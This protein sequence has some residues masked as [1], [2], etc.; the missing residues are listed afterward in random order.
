MAV[1]D[2]IDKVTELW[3]TVSDGKRGS[4][5]AYSA[6]KKDDWPES[7]NIFPSALSYVEH[8]NMEYG[9]GS[10]AEDRWIGFTEFHL[11]PDLGKHRYPGVLLFYNRIKTAV[12]ANIQLGGTVQTF[13]LN[14]DEGPSI[15]GPLSL[16]YGDEAPHWGLV[17]RWRVFEN[18]TGTFTV[19]A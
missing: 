12:A 5:H 16:T 11:Y 6:F 13:Y 7:I 2:W 18:T 9:V 14:T 10:P 1:E 15:E 8:A 4:V 17:V 3:A 19:S